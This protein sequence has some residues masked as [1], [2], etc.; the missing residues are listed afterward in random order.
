M[1]KDDWGLKFPPLSDTNFSGY[2]SW[3]QLVYANFFGKG[4]SML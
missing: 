4:S 2:L 1:S 3:S